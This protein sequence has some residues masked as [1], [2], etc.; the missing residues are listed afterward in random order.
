MSGLRRT[1]TFEVLG[2]A[3]QK[4]SMRAFMPKGAC[5][6][7][8]THDNRKPEWKT[9]VHLIAEG[10]QQASNGVL[11]DGPVTLDVA[12][13]LPRPKSLP[14]RV[15]WQTKHPDLDKLVRTVNDALI[16]VLFHDD[17]QVVEIRAS[18]AYATGNA[19]PRALITVRDVDPE[20]L[21]TITAPLFAEEITT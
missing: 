14:K 17:A 19:A 21:T 1:V 8:V 12:F 9:W 10:A 2:V 20:L 18:K 3:Q 6:P 5:Y 7:V 16:G 11:L 4:G 15:V 13:F